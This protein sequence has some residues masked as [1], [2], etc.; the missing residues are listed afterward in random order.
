M[1]LA[2]SCSHCINHVVISVFDKICFYRVQS[3][4]FVSKQITVELAT[5]YSHY[6]NYC[7]NSDFDIIVF[8]VL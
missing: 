5:S 1:E 4:S 8:L 3:V 7:D 2:T 6:D